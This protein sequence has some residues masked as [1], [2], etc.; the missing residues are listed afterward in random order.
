[1]LVLFAGA[2]GKKGDP[3]P[4]FPKGARAVTDLKIEQEAA[5]AT[6]TF[7]YPDRLL[8]GSALTDLAAVEVYRLPNP[9][10]SIAST[11]PRPA[12]PPSLSAGP[13]TDTAP[14]AGARRVAVSAHQ[15]EQSFY[16][17]AERIA[18]LPV[19]E[20]ARRTHG[21]SIVYT[22]PLPPILAKVRPL[23]S[24]AYAVVSVRRGGER[25]PLSNIVT[26]APEVPPA[27]PTLLAV[28]PE[29]GRICVEWLEPAS[30][31]LGGKPAKVGGYFVYRRPLPD[32]DYGD[33]LNPKPVSG[34]GYID[35]TAPYGSALVYTVRATLPEKP[36]IEGPPSD[37]AVVDY[38]DLFPPPAPARLDALSEASLVRLVWDP[39]AAP[40]LA[41]YAVFRSE[42]SAAPARLNAELVTDAT[43]T[44]AT[45][46]AG[47]RY[48]YT[49]RAVDR[50]GN[51]SAPSP[52]AKAEPF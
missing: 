15:A 42:G 7:T 31:L 27:A 32:E 48:V 12:V 49:V 25:S 43:Y 37:E 30:D 9:P 2:C 46:K 3:Q 5:D 40:D 18:S 10:A 22:D 29:E 36:K 19:G 34:T 47:H 24:I 14:A 1:V 16:T 20:I 23:S 44:D 17:A 21:A 13:K 11:T 41:G 28:T 52:E 51:A 50:A 8:D 39:V 33:P 6:L 35:T 38:R 45:A 26:L 4:P